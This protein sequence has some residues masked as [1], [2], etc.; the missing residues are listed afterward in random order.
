MT[1]I[2]SGS[3]G[4]RRLATPPGDATRPTSDRVREALFSRLEH[5]DVLVGSRVLDLYAG[6]GALGLEA[7][8]RGAVQASLVDSDRGA[9]GIARTNARALG[10]A[11]RVL[12]RAEPVEWVLITGPATPA[13]RV[14]LVF[15]DP[16]YDLA[17]ER[18]ADVL[19]LLVRHTWLAPDALVVVERSGRSAQPR[20]PAGLSASG[21]RRYG[22]TKVWFADAPGPDEVA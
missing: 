20:W 3:V 19:A 10:F 1:R 7:L 16:P 22:E 11:D 2:I 15:V 6:S 21:E 12:V 18:L 5:L 4:G 9:A 14:G 13:E 17:D 8:S